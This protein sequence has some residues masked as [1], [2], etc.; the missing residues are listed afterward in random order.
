MQD[1]ESPVE[2]LIVHLEPLRALD[3]AGDPIED[4]RTRLTSHEPVDVAGVGPFWGG[5]V[6]YFGYDV[7]AYQ[8]FV[9]A[10][11]AANS[12]TGQYRLRVNLQPTPVNANSFPTPFEYYS[13]S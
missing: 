7:A 1:L 3:P 5:A 9:F 8:I 10:L 13:A 12:S 11:S 6:G 4:L 2:G